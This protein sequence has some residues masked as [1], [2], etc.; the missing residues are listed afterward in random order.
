MTKRGNGEGSVYQTKDGR[1]RASILLSDGTRKYVSGKT[2]KEAAE[3]LAKVLATAA[4]GGHVASNRIAAGDWLDRWLK[5]EPA[6][7]NARW[8]EEETP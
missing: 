8:A 6:A 1:W 3:E 4:R 7:W 5:D 2:R